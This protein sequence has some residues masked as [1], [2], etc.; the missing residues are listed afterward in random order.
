MWLVVIFNDVRQ[1]TDVLDLFLGGK[2][3]FPPGLKPNSRRVVP[4]VAAEGEGL[5]AEV[6]HGGEVALV[7]DKFRQLVLFH[8]EDLAHGEGVVFGEGLPLQLLEEFPDAVG[9]FHHVRAGGQPVRTFSS[10]EQLSFLK[11]KAMWFGHLLSCPTSSV[12]TMSRFVK[13][14]VNV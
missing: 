12:M 1:E 10:S 3:G 11:V 4:A 13:P 5:G 9:G 2:Q 6:E 14:L 7:S 8:I